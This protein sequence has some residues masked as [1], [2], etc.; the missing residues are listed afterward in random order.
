MRAKVAEGYQA[1]AQQVQALLET[2]LTLVE[3]EHFLIWTD[4]ESVAR[5]KLAE[6]AEAMYTALCV[7]FQLDRASDVFLAK[8]PIFCFQSRSRLRRFA[9][10]IDGYGGEE[11]IAYTRSVPKSGH[12]H[13]VLARQGR[14][15]F[16]YDQFACNLVHE[17][18][19]AFLHRLHTSRLIP[20]WVNEGYAELV[21]DR[22]LGDRCVSRQDARL[23][24]KQ[25][26]AYDWSIADF[27]AGSEPVAVHQYPLAHS[28]V[29]YLVSLGDGRWRGLIRDVKGG[30]DLPTALAKQYDGLTLERLEAN[31]KGAVAA[32]QT[33]R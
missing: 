4:W 28:V 2:E 13:V 21:A 5:P 8:C 25:Y 19:H 33:K 16:A 23:L 27:L 7:E 3:T 1:F 30:A 32:S 14:S 31:W 15:R 24:A 22:V 6:W 10:R 20:H 29:R 9:Q 17:G 18:T 26:I 12:V 11:A